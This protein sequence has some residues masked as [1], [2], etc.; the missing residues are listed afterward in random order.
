[1]KKINTLHN[2]LVDLVGHLDERTASVLWAEDAL[3]CC[4][5]YCIFPGIVY[6]VIT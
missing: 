5:P 1:M 6:L 4:A 2:A 3:L